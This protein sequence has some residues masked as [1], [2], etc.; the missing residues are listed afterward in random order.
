MTSPE[1]AAE[2]PS[3]SETRAVKRAVRSIF[4]PLKDS[5]VTEGVRSLDFCV[6]PNRELSDKQ[7]AIHKKY[8]YGKVADRFVPR[9][10]IS[11]VKTEEG[12]G[13]YYGSSRFLHNLSHRFILDSEG[14]LSYHQEA[15]SVDCQMIGPRPVNLHGLD[16]VAVNN[17]AKTELFWL[18]DELSGVG[19]DQWK[20]GGRIAIQSC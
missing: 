8:G 13:L 10:T 17:Q 14:E 18:S 11:M 6:R 15:F 12:T 20:K 2:R 4:K 7:Y 3:W 9:S 5:P 19:P 1:T 16:E